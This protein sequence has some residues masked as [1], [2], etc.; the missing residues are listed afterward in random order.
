MLAASAPGNYVQELAQPTSGLSGLLLVWVQRWG[1]SEGQEHQSLPRG[2]WDPSQALLTL[3]LWPH[4]L[5]LSLGPLHPLGRISL[6]LD[7]V[8]SLMHC[9]TLQEYNWWRGG[10][11]SV[12]QEETPT[13]AGQVRGGGGVKGGGSGPSVPS[14]DCPRPPTA[15]STVRQRTLIQWVSR[16]R[17]IF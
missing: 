7:D 17:L 13:G 16:M 11:Q 1:C 5:V 8:C 3:L 2:G 4:S 6:P 10:R 12:S 15:L 14:S 9:H